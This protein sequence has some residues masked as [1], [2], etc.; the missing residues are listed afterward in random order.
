MLPTW[1]VLSRLSRDTTPGR[2]L[3]ADQFVQSIVGGT[4]TAAGQHRTGFEVAYG[5][6]SPPRRE[7]VPFDVF[8]ERWSRLFDDRGFIVDFVRVSDHDARGT[9]RDPISYLLFLGGE[10]QDH[11]KLETIR[12]DLVLARYEKQYAIA[13]YT[14]TDVPNPRAAR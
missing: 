14:L 13:D 5:L 3:A 11:A 2:Q 12:I 4:E 6:L 9:A 10:Q 7:S 8:F 1:I